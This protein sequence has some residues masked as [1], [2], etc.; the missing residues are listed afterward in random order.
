MILAGDEFGDVHDLDHT[1]W[2]MKMSD[3]V[4]WERLHSSENNRYLW[5]MVAEL[6]ALRTEH[7]ALTRNET[8]FIHFH[9]DFDQSH[10]AK[11]FVYCRT[12]GVA[13]GAK[14]QV[15]VIGNI[16]PQSFNHY[17]LPWYWMDLAKVKEI[18]PPQHR[19]PLEQND[20]GSVRLSLA[21][22]QVR[23]FVT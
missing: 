5:R 12:R 18:A 15:V 16:G 13:P 3:P 20:A 19:I 10:G 1:N 21:P 8:E 2:R 4:D 17:T 9:P 6:I 23:V 7:S 11:V 14:N 22:Y